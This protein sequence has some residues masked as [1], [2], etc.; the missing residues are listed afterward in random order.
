M[1]VQERHEGRGVSSGCCGLGWRRGKLV[2]LP[3]L[4]RTKIDFEI[5]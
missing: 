2:D 1:S 3:I 5:S 4:G